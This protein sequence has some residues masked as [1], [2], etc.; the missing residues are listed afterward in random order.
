[1]SEF[2]DHL[3]EQFE[4]FGPVTIRR[5]F[6]GHGVFRDGLMFG[7]VVDDGLYFKT[8]EHSRALFESRGLP[9]FEYTRK[10]QAHL[11]LLPSRAWR[12]A[13]GSARPCRMGTD[14]VRRRAS[15]KSDEPTV[16]DPCLVGQHAAL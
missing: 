5:M 16:K 1:M 15:R 7:L 11:A 13:G 10:K 2:V 4:E 8:D 14:R 6:G 9:R 12:R 3:T